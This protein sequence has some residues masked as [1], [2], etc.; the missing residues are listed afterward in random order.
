LNILKKYITFEAE[1]HHFKGKKYRLK[2]KLEQ[3]IK[4]EKPKLSGVKE[5]RI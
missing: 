3:N 4:I 1:I 2:L 5:Q